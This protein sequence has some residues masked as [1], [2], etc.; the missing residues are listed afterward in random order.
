MTDLARWVVLGCS[1]LLA[2]C[3]R[4]PGTGP[5][6][7]KWDRVACERCRMLVSDRRYA[8]QV[9]IAEPEGR[10]KTFAFDDIGCA[11]VWLEGQPR[12]VRESPSTE[13]WVTDWRNGDWID[14]RA[15]TYISGRLTPME[16]GLGAQL[17]PVKGG[18]GFARAK[19]RI[20][21]VERRFDIHGA[22]LDEAAAGASAQTP[23]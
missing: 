8:A 5:V 22:H 16:Y 20:L 19:E 4:D 2:A 11:L 18:L 3:D 6:E 12:A 10:S 17:Q 23:R 15:A 1:M 13:I 14:A 7:I 9:R 21:E